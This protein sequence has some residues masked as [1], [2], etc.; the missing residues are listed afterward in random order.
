MVFYVNKTLVEIG[1]S[2]T[3]RLTCSFYYE[4]LFLKLVKKHMTWPLRNAVL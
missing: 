2:V 3:F 4:E 1:W